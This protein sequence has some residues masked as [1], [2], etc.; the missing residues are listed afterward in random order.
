MS[1]LLILALKGALILALASGAVALLRT[2]PAAARHGIWVAAFIG[3]LALPLLATVGPAWELGILPESLTEPAPLAPE[4]DPV[5]P[6]AWLCARMA[7]EMAGV[8][9]NPSPS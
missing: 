1:L 8:G 9:V 3:L 4:A 7:C 6:E 2:A 5:P